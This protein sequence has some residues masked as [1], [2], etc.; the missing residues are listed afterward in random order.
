MPARDVLQAFTEAASQR[1][2]DAVQPFYN[3]V[4]KFGADSIEALVALSLSRRDL[5]RAVR[6]N[7]IDAAVIGGG[8]DLSAEAKGILQDIIGQDTY[9]VERFADDMPRLS[10]GQA[11][12]RANLYVN[13]QRNTIN[14]IVSL[15]MPTLP[16]YPRDA[17]LIC[18]WHCKCDLDVRFLFGKGNFDVIWRLDPLG[19]EHCDDCL[20]LAATWR[21]LQIRGGKILNMKMVRPQDIERL[22][23]AFARMAA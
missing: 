22:K 2:A 5:E 6:E 3:A 11:L 7:H 20:R 13:T 16:M 4:D 19:R 17:R 8:G 14:D 15:E 10:R 1:M 21:P 18:T 9:F 12:V 23:M